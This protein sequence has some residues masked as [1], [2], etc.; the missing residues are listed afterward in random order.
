MA[1]TDQN[2]LKQRLASHIKGGEAFMTIERILEK[3]PFHQTG[4]IPSGLSYSFYQVFWH[5]YM[6]QHDLLQYALDPFFDSPPWP[7]GYWPE[8]TVPDNESEWEDLLQSYFR[9]R[10]RFI[11]LIMDPDQDLFKRFPNGTDHDLLRQAEL[12][13]EHQAYHTGQLL[14]ILR[15]LGLHGDD[16]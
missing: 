4:A 16:R 14:L 11:E 3:M 15:L 13:I 7:D 2:A 8:R 6:A 10:D 1:V 9:D 12:V 5:T